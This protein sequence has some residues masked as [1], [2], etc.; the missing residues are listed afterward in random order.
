MSIELRLDATDPTPPYEQLR[1]QFVDLMESAV[2]TEGSRLPPVRQLAA[3]LGIA[4]GTVARTYRE[5][6]KAGLIRTRR[7]A[8]TRVSGA[9]HVTE[10]PARTHRV[11][12]LF[13]EA[14]QRARLWGAS[15]DEIA[16][17][18]ARA[19]VSGPARERRASV[20]AQVSVVDHAGGH[21][22]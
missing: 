7:G 12:Q 21:E 4:T 16:A 19:L 14:V 13:I 15:E 11:E 9:A 20:A 17:S 18:F 6:E 2:L 5:L 3:D 22:R 8:G 1:R 10:S